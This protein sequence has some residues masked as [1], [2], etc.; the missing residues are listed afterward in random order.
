MGCSFE[1]Q[2]GVKIIKAFQ[3]ILF[4]PEKRKSNTMCIGKGSEF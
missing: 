1:R 3:K 2:K 4:E